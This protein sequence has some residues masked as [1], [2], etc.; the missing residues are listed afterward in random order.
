MDEKSFYEA[1]GDVPEA[2][3]R[4][5]E[6]VERHVRRSGVKRRTTLAACLLLAFIIPAL[7]FKQLNT[8]S[9]A[10]AEE[11][12][13]M[14]ELFYAFEFL[15]GDNEL[16]WLLHADA[17]FVNNGNADNNGKAL[18]MTEKNIAKNDGKRKERPNED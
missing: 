17:D 6:N 2:P 1:L 7:V 14:D 5:L 9:T 12:E 10:Y 13:S 15:S 16:D 11:S 4:V 8:T 18:T 3:I